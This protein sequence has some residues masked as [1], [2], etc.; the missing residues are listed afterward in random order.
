[1]L[2]FSSLPFFPQLFLILRRSALTLSVFLLV[3]LSVHRV[4]ASR[5]FK[6]SLW[7]DA[8]TFDYLCAFMSVCVFVV[9]ATCLWGF[10]K[11]NASQMNAVKTSTSLPRKALIV[12]FSQSVFMFAVCG[13]KTDICWFFTVL[14]L[15]YSLLFLSCG[16]F[17]RSP[18]LYLQQMLKS[19]TTKS[20]P[21]CMSPTLTFHVK[22]KGFIVRAYSVLHEQKVW[23]P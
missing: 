15:S 21:V 16:F 19:F 4:N 17:T 7:E 10:V 2:S 3:C 8:L 18:K 11:L 5:E 13:Q 22:R 23:Y 12:N 1:M 9:I 20:K 6:G 14:F